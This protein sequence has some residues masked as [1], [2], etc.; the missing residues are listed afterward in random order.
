[1]HLTALEH[2]SGAHH[3]PFGSSAVRLQCRR[4]LRLRLRSIRKRPSLNSYGTP[5]IS[6][7]RFLSC[8]GRN[9]T[10]LLGFAGRDYAGGEIVKRGSESG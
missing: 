1:L 7:R 9:D 6:T 8:Q 4:L 3:A 5:E 2:V 10:D